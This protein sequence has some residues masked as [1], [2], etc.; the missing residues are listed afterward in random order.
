[1]RRESDTK[2]WKTHSSQGYFARPSIQ[3]Y[4]DLHTY[5]TRPRSVYSL[6][7]RGSVGSWR[8]RGER[9]SWLCGPEENVEELQKGIPVMNHKSEVIRARERGQRCVRDQMNRIG[10]CILCGAVCKH[11]LVP[12][13]RRE[14]RSQSRRRLPGNKRVWNVE[15]TSICPNRVLFRSMRG[16]RTPTRKCHDGRTRDLSKAVTRSMP[17]TSIRA[18]SSMLVVVER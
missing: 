14:D 12:R 15:G 18:T 4:E 17:R 1:M 5:R 8:G 3:S 11:S 2:S 6:L 16:L 7:W 13:G 9:A 10:R